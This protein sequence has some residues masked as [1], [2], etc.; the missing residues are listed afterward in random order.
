M[1]ENEIIYP[2]VKEIV[3]EE[4]EYPSNYIFSEE[5]HRYQYR[6]VRDYFL[7]TLSGWSVADF[8]SDIPVDKIAIYALTDFADFVINDLKRKGA[9]QVILSDKKAEKYPDGY[10]NNK[11]YTPKELYLEYERKNVSKVI[12]CSFF[13][14]N[15]I[16]QELMDIGFKLNDIVTITTILVNSK[17]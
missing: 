9:G 7:K 4:R 13:H 15:E 10:E 16:M 17:S 3:I 14:A 6:F 12:V 2:G 8:F 11:V 5:W 1:T